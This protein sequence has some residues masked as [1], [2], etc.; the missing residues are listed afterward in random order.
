MGA[1]LLDG[2]T[3]RSRSVFGSRDRLLCSVARGTRKAVAQVLLSAGWQECKHLCYV[4][5]DTTRLKAP[6]VSFCLLLQLI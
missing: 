5:R 3:V 6:V 2:V 4:A 1:I